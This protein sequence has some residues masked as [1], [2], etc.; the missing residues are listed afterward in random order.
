MNVDYRN[1]NDP[2]LRLMRYILNG[3]GTKEK[4]QNLI[5][6]GANVNFVNGRGAF[7]SYVGYSLLSLAAQYNDI[8]AIELL[9]QNGA[10]PNIECQY[11]P[12]FVASTKEAIDTLIKYGADPFATIKLNL[13]DYYMTTNRIQLSNYIETIKR[14]IAAQESLE[15][16]GLPKDLTKHISRYYFSKKKNL[17]TIKTNKN[18]K[19]AGR[20]IKK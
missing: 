18:K 5:D 17:R 16:H 6:N 20:S 8:G 7:I 1:L 3:E 11:K 12:L 19:R 10:D 15:Y 4:M 9:I 2:T 13:E 14:S